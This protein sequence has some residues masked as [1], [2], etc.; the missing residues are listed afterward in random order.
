MCLFRIAE[1][2]GVHEIYQVERVEVKRA[3]FII[4][5][6]RG[7][8]KNRIRF[9][10]SIQLALDNFQLHVL[11]KSGYIKG[12]HFLQ[13]LNRYEFLNPSAWSDGHCP[14]AARSHSFVYI[15]TS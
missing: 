7:A 1:S 8:S 4:L 9:V 5:L 2:Y 14:H 13:S 3:V 10:G 12:K 11:L 15:S 6:L